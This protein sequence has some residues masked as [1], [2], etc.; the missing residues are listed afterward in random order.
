MHR[1]LAGRRSCIQPREN[2]GNQWTMWFGVLWSDA[3]FYI[4][5]HLT[6]LIYSFE[7]E[8]VLNDNA[9]QSDKALGDIP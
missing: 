9:R 7:V 5:F 4:L 6:P 8:H 3:T 1:R 2:L